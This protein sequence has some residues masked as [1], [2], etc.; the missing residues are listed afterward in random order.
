MEAD[1]TIKVETKRTVECYQF[2]DKRNGFKLEKDIYK[3]IYTGLIYHRFMIKVRN[4]KQH[5]G[6]QIF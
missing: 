5:K 2:Y 6:L 1:M 4:Y 3:T